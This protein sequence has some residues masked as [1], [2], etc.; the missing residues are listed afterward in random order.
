MQVLGGLAHRCGGLVDQPLR[1]EA[2]VEVDVGAHRVMA[3]VLDPAGERDVDGAE[4][5]LARR[6]RDRGERAGAHPVDGEA[7]DRVGNAGEQRDVAPER[8][9]LVAHLRRRREHDV[10]DPLRG[11]RRVPAEQLADDLH[12]HVIGPRPPVLALRPRLAERRAD[13]VDEKDLACLAH[14]RAR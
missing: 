7:R 13:P 5:D 1:D 10:A 12:T 8:Q 11:D 9:A 4:R 2:R 14:H 3:H 6:R